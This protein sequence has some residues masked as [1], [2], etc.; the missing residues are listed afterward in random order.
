MF[1]N[2]VGGGT[3]G[4]FAACL[5]LAAAAAHAQSGS[6]S[7]S[8]TIGVTATVLS[9]S[10]CLFTTTPAAALPLG[11]I[12]PANT[13]AA[14]ASI[15]AAFRCF[16]SARNAIFAV[17]ASNGLYFNGKRRMRHTNTASFLPYSLTVGLPSL[18]VLWGARVDLT[19]TGTVAVAD[20]Q[21]AVVGSY[22]DRI[23]VTVDP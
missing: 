10:N 11:Q 20:F 19:L 13:V 9:R 18:T 4:L 14:S 16:G 6:G 5:G 7:G 1:G 2:A 12:N 3:R 15:A 22:T 23:T 8:G 21:D 17:T